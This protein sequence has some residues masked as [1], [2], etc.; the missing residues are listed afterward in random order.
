LFVD[1]DLKADVPDETD[2]CGECDLCIRSCPTQA[3][4]NKRTVAVSRCISFLTTNTKGDIPLDLCMKVGDHVFGCDICQSVCPLNR[5]IP[6]IKISQS[7]ILAPI[8][9]E[10]IDL[11]PEMFI[12]ERSYFEK[13]SPTPIGKLPHEVFLRNLIIAAG[14]SGEGTLIGPLK[15]LIRIHPSFVVQNA[16]NWAISA[17]DRTK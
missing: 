3:I 11:L 6:D 15:D 17:I 2:L 12:S 4:S 8:I 16:A 10:K 14:N 1:F 7:D 5:D 9:N 13:Y